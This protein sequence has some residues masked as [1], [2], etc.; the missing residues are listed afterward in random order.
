ME[1]SSVSFVPLLIVIGLAFLVPLTLSRFK[2]LGIPI[3]VGE[4][5]SGIIVGKSGFNLIQEGFVLRILSD[6]GFAYLMFLSGLEINFSAVLN[7]GPDNDGANGWQRL[8]SNPL[9]AGV[10]LFILTLIASI[11]VGFLIWSQ[12]LIQSPWIMALIISTTSL[13]V[14][15]PVLKERGLTEGRYGQSILMAALV[16]DFATILLISIFVLLRSQGFTVEILLVLVLFAAFVVVYRVAALFQEHLPAQRIIEELSSA[17][18]QIKLRG[19]FVLAFVFIALAESLGIEIILGAFL[20]GVI[21]SLLSNGDDDILQQKL[22]AIGYG[23]FIPIFF[24]MV[25]GQFDLPALLS[26][27]SALLLVP[28]IIIAA[29]L[30]KFIPALL[31]RLEYSWRETIAAGVLLSAR[32]SLIIAAAAIGLQL[33]IISEAVNAAIILVAVITCTVSPILFNLLMPQTERERR[34]MIVVGARTSA[35][36]LTNRLIERGVDTV[37]VSSGDT[38]LEQQTLITGEASPVPCKNHIRAGG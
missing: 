7:N 3:V 20:A 21:V 6:L 27:Q 32:L 4:I 2:K 13:G 33:G 30:V 10:I 11:G 31:Y 22:D 36:L 23:F 12:N 19:S 38:S 35:A 5:I 9:P 14:V 8:L 25:G 29:Y 24:V 37:L 15:V 34:R 26:S 1:H 16:A 28:L 18:S 17:T